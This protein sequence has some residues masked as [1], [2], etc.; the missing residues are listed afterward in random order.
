MLELE[1]TFLAKFIPDV[2]QCKHKE[3]FD[4]YLPKN[5][6]HPNL[7]IRKN[8]NKFEIT[9][10]TMVDNDPS[11]QLEHNIALSEDEF[12][13]LS[14]ADG[15]IV[16]KIRY[17]YNYNGRTAEIDIFQEDLYGLVLVDFEFDKEEDK[18]NFPL[19]DFCLLD[20]T[21]IEFIAGG[22]LCGRKY[23]DIEA[24]LNQLGYQKL[25]Y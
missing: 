4:I 15:K 7:R 11:K 9:K 6:Y 21:G 1:K 25:K 8:G 12:L 5:S 14:K 23:Q 17:Y 24:Q 2:S 22:M 10:K 16:K 19:P 13:S 18:N 3:L 20:V